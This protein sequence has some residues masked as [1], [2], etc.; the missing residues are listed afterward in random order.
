MPID[1]YERLDAKKCVTTPGRQHFRDFTAVSWAQHANIMMNL[2]IANYVRRKNRSVNSFAGSANLH[3]T[4]HSLVPSIIKVDPQKFRCWVRER[5]DFTC[6]NTSNTVAYITITILTNRKQLD[7][8]TPLHIL[9][10]YPIPMI[11]VPTANGSGNTITGWTTPSTFD[12]CL[13]SNGSY[14]AV[15]G[16]GTAIFGSGLT[17]G[18]ND[19]LTY[20]RPFHALMQF[21]PVGF[22]LK[23]VQEAASFAS[24]NAITADN[25]DGA[26][27]TFTSTT[28]T[29]GA[30]PWTT[31]SNTLN[32]TVTATDYENEWANPFGQFGAA[33]GGY[34][35]HPM[36]REK[37]RGPM[38]VIFKRRFKRI[39]LHPGQS[40]AF[41]V[42]SGKYVI[43]PMHSGL[44]RTSYFNMDPSAGTVGVQM[45]NGGSWWGPDHAAS[46]LTAL[47]SAVYNMCLGKNRGMYGKC[48]TKSVSFNIHGNTAV[49]AGGYATDNLNPLG[50]TSVMIKRRYRAWTRGWVKKEPPLGST[51][52]SQMAAIDDNVTSAQYINMYPTA[53]PAQA[54]YFSL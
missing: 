4:T 35:V 38:D 3:G 12:P 42:K 40:Y 15:F 22:N 7:P 48:A 10:V 53:V 51:K 45:D 9:R 16:M 44:W 28:T 18:A 31:L 36:Y 27:G 1:A 17:A 54:T 23:A 32:K 34:E 19:T 26:P 33:V 2:A 47:P 49:T 29:V 46:A 41:T 8:C 39:Q 14:L 50:P 37:Q 13:P 6:Y 43:D 21:N 25:I 24:A 30:S 52:V 20:L 11:K 5:A